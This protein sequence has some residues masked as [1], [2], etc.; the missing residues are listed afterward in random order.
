MRYGRTEYERAREMSLSSSVD[1]SRFNITNQ[2][3]NID[4]VVISGSDSKKTNLLFNLILKT[5]SLP[6]IVVTDSQRSR[7]ASLL[8]NTPESNFSFV[9]YNGNSSYYN[10]L[11]HKNVNTMLQFF[12]QIANEFGLFEQQRI[13]SETLLQCILQLSTYSTNVFSIIANGC[14]TGEYLLNEINRLT[15]L[16]NI[17]KSN[18]IVKVNS[19]ITAA[20]NVSVAFNDLFYIIANMSGI[21][22]SVK[23]IIDRK[24][25]VCFCLDGNI[26]SRNGCW[27]LSKM[28]SFDLNNHLSD[29]SKN[30]VLVL[31]VSNKQKLEMFSDLIGVY[32]AKVIM[33]VDNSEYLSGNFSASH[34]QEF[35]IFS[36]SDINS[37]KYWSDF[38]AT[39]KAAEYTYSS[40]NTT[41]NKYPLLPLNIGSIFGE[42]NENLSLTYKIVDKPVFEI[43]EIRELQDLEFIYYSHVSRKAVKYMLR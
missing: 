19:S 39:R 2:P 10:F 27:Y 20:Q 30:F 24:R 43:N 9:R 26:T 42:T 12:S 23:D 25:H 40:S 35:Y 31:D 38:F 32:I 11:R 17:E 8:Q 34:F 36:H 1:S 3:L 28:L 4:N 7:L 18:L 14:I 41:T 37:A 22:F 13:Q 5:L 16:T 21:P 33:C 6:I 29:S 15:G